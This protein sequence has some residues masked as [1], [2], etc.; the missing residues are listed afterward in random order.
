MKYR[1]G[2]ILFSGI[3]LFS[4]CMILLLLSGCATLN[5]EECLNADWYSIGYVDGA[6]GYPA[7]KIGDH[8]QACAEYSVKPEFDQYD[9]GRIAGLAEYCNPRNGY[10]LG[11][12]GAQYRGVCPKNL[13]GAFIAAY[14]QGKNVYEMDRQVKT[15]EKEM[16]GLY[17]ELDNIEREMAGDEAELVKDG[18]TRRRRIRLLDKIKALSE[19]QKRLESEIAAKEY[20]L[21]AL[22]QRL[23][24]IKTQSPYR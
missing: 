15:G 14:Q 7:S 23:A 22:R 5:K 24:R 3:G 21:E 18:T 1:R 10:W 12:K 8:R 17:A 4:F 2:A 19:E 20:A 9:A 11:T 13:E 16:Q 6:R